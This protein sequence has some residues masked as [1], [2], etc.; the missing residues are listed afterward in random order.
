VG[1]CS[2]AARRA[3]CAAIYE[4][5]A[6]LNSATGDRRIAGV[7]DEAPAGPGL[8]AITDAEDGRLVLDQPTLPTD[9][10]PDIFDTNAATVA[11][12]LADH[13]WTGRSVGPD[14]TQT[15]PAEDPFGVPEPDGPEELDMHRTVDGTELVIHATITD[16]E[17]TYRIE[18]VTPLPA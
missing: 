15:W 1:A 18:T 2:P 16:D 3:A 7:D 11:R 13:G 14:G 4:A 10:R 12:E 9:R 5:A 6:T 17:T 8:A